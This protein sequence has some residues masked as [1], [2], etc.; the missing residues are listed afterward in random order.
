M[1]DEKKKIDLMNWK[2]QAC[3]NNGGDINFEEEELPGIDKPAN[4]ADMGFMGG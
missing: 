4:V 3:L 1:L 2:Y